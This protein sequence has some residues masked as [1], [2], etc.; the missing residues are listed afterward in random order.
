LCVDNP[1]NKFPLKEMSKGEAQGAD[2]S[3]FSIH[4]TISTRKKKK[5]KNTHKGYNEMFHS[6]SISQEK[7]KRD[8]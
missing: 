6:N 4:T 1:Q 2:N 3:T 8:K 7:E 5:K